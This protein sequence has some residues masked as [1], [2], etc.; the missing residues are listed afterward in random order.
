MTDFTKENGATKIL[1]LSHHIHGSGNPRPMGD[2]NYRHAIS[3]DAPAGSI[4]LFHGRM[5][6]T[7]ADDYT[8]QDRLAWGSL[9]SVRARND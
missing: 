4:V 9:W 2:T 5:W 8:D 1:P 6:H 7:T 3:V